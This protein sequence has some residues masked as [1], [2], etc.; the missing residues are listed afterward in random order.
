MAREFKDSPFRVNN[1]KRK[2]PEF[3]RGQLAAPALKERLWRSATVPGWPPTNALRIDLQFSPVSGLFASANDLLIQAYRVRRPAL[4]V[5]IFFQ[6]RIAPPAASDIWCRSTHGRIATA[7]RVYPGPYSQGADKRG[8]H[9]EARQADEVFLVHA[10][11][12]PAAPGLSVWLK[13]RLVNP[14]Q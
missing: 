6:C 1:T 4:R 12:C 7:G 13:T 14:R 10:W 2:S 9:R 11:L 3:L 8:S 5:M